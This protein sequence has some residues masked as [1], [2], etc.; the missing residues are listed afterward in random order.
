MACGTDNL[1]HDK[2]LVAALVWG[3]RADW[4]DGATR[5]E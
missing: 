4:P 1:P 2:R 5:I 3:G